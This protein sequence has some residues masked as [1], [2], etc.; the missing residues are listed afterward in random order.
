M[1]PYPLIDIGVNLMHKSFAGDRA[2]VLARAEAQ[3]VYRS[4]ITGTDLAS[5]EAAASFTKTRP[6]FLYSTAG[7][8]PHHAKAFTCE[9]ENVLRRLWSQP[10]VVAIGECGLDFDRN[11]SPRPEQEACFEAHLKVAAETGKPLFLHERAAHRR[12]TELLTAHKNTV[13]NKAVVHCFTGS[14]D[15]LRTYLDLGCYIGITGWVCD[16]RRGG[17]LRDA[18]R[19]LPLDR[20]MLETD[21]PFLMPR[22]MPGHQKNNRNEPAFLPYVLHGVADALNKPALEIAQITSRTAESFFGL[23]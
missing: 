20:L 21:A 23:V 8:H 11:F 4:I 17:T 1:T 10:Q 16:E 15:E 18:L 22:T 19:Y 2:Q 3:G 6:G 9:A 14:T 7:F 13:Y 5:S 12:F